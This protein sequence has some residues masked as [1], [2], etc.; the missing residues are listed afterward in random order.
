MKI[1]IVTGFFLPVPPVQGGS[2]EKIWHRLSREFARAGHEVTFIS[3]AWPGLARKETVEGVTHLRLMGADH[4]RWL[5]VNL[6][7]DF[8]WGLRV[9]F[10][11]PAADIVIC[12]TVTLPVWLRWLKPSAGRVAAVLARMPKGHGRFYGGVDLLLS[13]SAA[14]TAKLRAENP[15]L[16]N[17]IVPFPYPIDWE[18][19][20]RA[21]MQ[22][23]AHPFPPDAKGR[24]TIGF[25]GRIHPEKG[26]RLLLA[27]AERLAQRTNLPAWRLELIGPSEVAQGGGGSIF[28]EALLSDFGPALGDRVAFTGPD[29]NPVSLARRYGRMAVFCYPSIAEQGETFGVSVAEAMAAGAVPVVSGLACFQE[30]VRDGE[31]GLVFDHRRPGAEDRLADALARLL[32]DEGL[33]RKLAQRAQDHARHYDYAAS[34]RTVLADFTRLTGP[35]KQRN[36]R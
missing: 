6:V 18:L 3:R 4:R 26:L 8:W 19:H 34:A 12:N 33:R 35:G 31:T 30:L 10:A 2:T 28:R 16:G 23:S 17:R 14:V 36:A 1:T 11:L 5:P 32:A 15:R 29:F 7:L 25:V 21:S 22:E 13:L 20:A 27:A 24:L 9:G